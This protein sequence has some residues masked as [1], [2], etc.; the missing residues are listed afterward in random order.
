[1]E[2]SGERAEG[3]LV[4][5]LHGHDSRGGQ[6]KFFLMPLGI[7]KSVGEGRVAP[8]SE[9]AYHAFCEAAFGDKKW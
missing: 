3:V 8:E 5:L 9:P 7:S 6:T 4:L 1:M 2:D